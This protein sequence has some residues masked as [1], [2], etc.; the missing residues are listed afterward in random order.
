MLNVPEDAVEPNW[1]YVNTSLITV[2]LADFGCG[3]IMASMGSQENSLTIEGNLAY[4]APEVLEGKI[5][6]LDK[7]KYS[8][9]SDIWSV[10]AVAYKCATGTLPGMMPF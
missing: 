1:K 5:R 4:C 9:K 10:A 8:K 6:N 3:R 7:I 2:K